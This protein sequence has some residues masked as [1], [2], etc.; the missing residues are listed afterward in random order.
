MKDEEIEG[1]TKRTYEFVKENPGCHLRKIKNELKVSMGTVQYHLEKLEKA[2][3]ITSQRHGLH[4]YYF[5]IGTFKENEKQLL[6]V[7]SYETTREILMYLAEQKTITKE[8]SQIDIA[9]HVEISSA[10][11][12]WHIKRLVASKVIDEIIEGKTKRYKIH[13][14]PQLVVALLR[15]YYPSIWDSWSDRLAELFL[16]MSNKS[17]EEREKEEKQ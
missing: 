11:V 3:R 12:N 9:R 14:D 5:V 7:L 8:P 4:K 16:A 17:F 13:D 15:N 1:N 2:G 6:E 10:S